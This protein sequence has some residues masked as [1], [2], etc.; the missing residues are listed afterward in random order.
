MGASIRITCNTRHAQ[1]RRISA[2]P[3]SAITVSPNLGYY[4]LAQ[5]RLLQSPPISAITISH[6]LG[7]YNLGIWVGCSMMISANSWRC[8][9]PPRR[10]SHAATWANMMTSDVTYIAHT[11]HSLYCAPSYRDGLREPR[12][13][14]ER[15]HAVSPYEGA[16]PKEEE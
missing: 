8:N 12:A 11:A 6:N 4:N 15:P 7:Y 13:R 5:S 14:G 10:A 2:I 16:N 1:S 3:I 9:A